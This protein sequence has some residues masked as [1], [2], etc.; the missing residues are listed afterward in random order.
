MGR[1][2]EVAHLF[3]VVTGRRATPPTPSTPLPPT[4]PR[5][6]LLCMKLASE[7]GVVIASPWVTWFAAA[8]VPALIGLAIAPLVVFKLNPPEAGGG[9]QSGAG[10]GGRAA[11]G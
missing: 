3:P 10:L 2:G 7:L 11:R 4:H 5:Q 8:A 1:C 6:N 9:R